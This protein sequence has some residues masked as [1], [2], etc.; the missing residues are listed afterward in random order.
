M[1][2]QIDKGK[3]VT[4]LEFD[5][6][7]LARE[8]ATD[9]ATA[10]GGRVYTCTVFQQGGRRMLST[11]FP[12]PFLSKQVRLDPA[13]KGGNPRGNMNRPLMLDHVK[14]IR[15]Y[16]LTNPGDYVLPPVTL[17]LRYS[18]QL[19]VQRSNYPYRI[20]YL[21]V[22]DSTMFD[23]TDG[24]HRIAA[25]AGSAYFKPP[26]LP[27]F[28]E[29]ESFESDSM[30]ALVIIEE[31]MERIHQDFADAAQTKQIPASLLAA[32]NTREPVNRLLTKVVDSS[33]FLQNRVDETAK[34]LPK[35]SQSVFLLN[36]IRGFLKE[37][38]VGNNALSELTLAP[39]AADLL[40]TGE[41]QDAWL[42]RSLEVL[43][44]LTSSME[45]WKTISEID[46]TDSFANQIP[47]FRQKFVNM[48]G[49]G[50]M[51]IGRVAHSIQ[52]RV[53]ENERSA[54][55]SRLAEE[56]DWRRGGKLWNGNIVIEGRVINSRQSIDTATKRVKEALGLVD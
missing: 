31:N 6:L 46:P 25:I 36:Q 32:Y 42:K 34:T 9:D 37:I 23:V 11:S 12:F 39:L 19:Y 15:Q 43:D 8:A 44:S 53:P 52:K 51:V 48:S 14:A 26:I 38:L 49:A 29:N 1:S 54:M 55:Y 50:L 24:Q 22:G 5:T 10:S 21:V 45:P 40:A 2:D 56:I 18:P 47:E 17:N 13:T 41:R 16:L 30:A 35:L 33:R 20:G 4:E 3:Q 27:I 7:N 28:I